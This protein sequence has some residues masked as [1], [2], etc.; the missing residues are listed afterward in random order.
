MCE[1]VWYVRVSVCERKC[2]G[3]CRGC[4]VCEGKCVCVK[5]S[6]VCVR[7]CPLSYG[8]PSKLAYILI[9]ILLSLSLPPP[10]S[11]PLPP[12]SLPSL[13]SNSPIQAIARIHSSLPSLSYCHFWWSCPLY[14]QRLSSSRYSVDPNCS[15]PQHAHL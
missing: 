3:K 7:V 4:V 15:T 9:S 2:E 10:P 8:L 5:V 13:S 6:S 14:T 12:P 1:G 11:L